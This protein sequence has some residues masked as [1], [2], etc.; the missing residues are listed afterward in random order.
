MEIVETRTCTL[1]TT[2][3][4]SSVNKNFCGHAVI[5]TGTDNSRRAGLQPHTQYKP[6][7]AL[8]DRAHAPSHALSN[9]HVFLFPAHLCTVTGLKQ[10]INT[11]P[12]PLLGFHTGSVTN[13]HAHHWMTDLHLRVFPSATHARTGKWDTCPAGCRSVVGIGIPAYQATMV[14]DMYDQESQPHW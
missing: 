9:T 3:R 8:Q 10:Y 14:N 5:S 6:S 13:I 4:N 2:I 12:L 11:K 7:P 1:T